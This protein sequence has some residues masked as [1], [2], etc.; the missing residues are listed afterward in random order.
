MPVRF[1]LVYD[2]RNPAQWRRPWA[3]HFAGL[4][5]QIVFAEA[6]GFDSVWIT[7]HHFVDDGYTPSPIALLAAIA[8]RTKR[9]QLSTDILLLPLYNALKLAEDIATIDVLSGGRMMLGIGMGYR[10]EEFAAFGT[11]RRERVGRTEEGIDVLRG[12]WGDAP[13]TYAGRFYKL[14]GV[15][16]T[17]KPVQRPYPP[18][19]LAATSEP[20]ARRAARYGLNLLPQHD[21]TL[22]YDPWLDELGRLEKNPA[23]YRIGL[24]KPWFVADTGRGDEVW[25]QARQGE[26]YRAEVYQPW[27]R[28]GGFP[29]PPAGKS[30]PIDQGY[31]V[32]PPSELVERLSALREFMPVTDFISWGTPVGM[33]PADPGIRR[34][35]ERFAAEVIPRFRS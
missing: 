16:V 31:I 3:E 26:R 12:A 13:F 2:F 19:W 35:L 27:I 25:Q 4:L 6:L 29:T 20:A 30:R 22:A 23:D 21:R 33:D 18:L 24:I 32:G 28:A 17:P 34:S 14:D 11:S 7:E 10:D 15:N 8:A 5:D 9:L 1:G